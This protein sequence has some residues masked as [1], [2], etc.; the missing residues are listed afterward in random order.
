MKSILYTLFFTMM[1]TICVS[2]DN[3]AEN[4]PAGNN[5]SELVIRTGLNQMSNMLKSGPVSD[6]PEGSQLGLFITKGNLGDNYFSTASRNVLSTFT[7]GKWKQ[8]PAINLYSHNAVIYAYFP[9]V[10]GLIDGKNAA[11]YSGEIDYMYGTHTP[12]QA[13]INK[14]NPIVNL[15]MKHACA[16]VQFNI[17][18]TNYPW[19]GKLTNMTISNAPGKSCMYIYGKLNI[20]T[21]EIKDMSVG[22]NSVVKYGVLMTVPDIKS[23]DE[24]DF[25]KLLMIPTTKTIDKGDI[26]VKFTIDAKEYIWEIPAG[27]QWKQGTKN[28][29]DV[30]L[31]GH[32]LRIGEVKIA[33]WTDGTGGN[34]FLE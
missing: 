15:T 27:T 26:L 9:Y 12:G 32:E 19:E 11:V 6:F 4:V 5:A 28:T 18:K 21:G 13:D 25:Q 7:G 2:C 23:T 24:K 14:D 29:Y 31:N 34:A 1:L 3:E 10:S 16:L 17:H 8:T 22:N 30:M 20:Q 33:D